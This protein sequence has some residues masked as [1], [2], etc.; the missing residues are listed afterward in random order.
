MNR[1]FGSL[2]AS[3]IGACLLGAGCA[4]DVPPVN[5]PR[6]VV[7]E[8][9]QPLG[10]P[11]GVEAFPGA[12]RARIEADLSFRVPGK[13]AARRVDLGSRVERGTVIAVLDPQDARLNLEAA[14]AALRA[15][16]ADVWLAKEEERRYHDL[17]GHGHVSQSAV[18]LRVNTRQLAEARAEQARSQLQLAQNQSR[19]TQLTADAAGVVTQVMAEPGNVVAAGQPVVRVA[20]DGEREVRIDV[21]EGRVDAIRKAALIFV[22]IYTQPGKRYVARVR[23]V[24]P[25][26][27]PATRTHEARVTVLEP[28]A[29][30]QPGVTA[31]VTT[32]D[33]AD[34][35]TF[36]LPATALGALS[37]DRPAVWTVTADDQGASTVKPVPVLVLQYLDGAV[38]VAGPLQPGDRLVTAGVHR[39]VE[40]MAVQPIE[41]AAKAA[42]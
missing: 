26:A 2:A 38:I 21:P 33:M 30:V 36:R 11:A 8:A 31:T 35:N 41:R 1:L 39:L 23:E 20:Q 19:Y 16:E 18:D 29:A 13:I 22:E 40:G 12:V 28:D 6:P 9:P 42:L 4:R 32:A 14:R 37:G 15:A 7:V 24:S 3:A 25:A 27:N 17:K 10:G 34:G 5:A